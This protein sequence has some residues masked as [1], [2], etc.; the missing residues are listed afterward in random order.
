M[1]SDPSA[2]DIQHLIRYLYGQGEVAQY[3]R[4]T[5]IAMGSSAVD[6][7]IAV[8]RG[9]Y[10]IEEAKDPSEGRIWGFLRVMGLIPRTG[11]SKLQVRAE[12]AGILAEIGDHRA[13]EPLVTAF[14]NNALT[15]ERYKILDALCQMVRV[16]PDPRLI[17]V[18]IGVLDHRAWYA[19]KPHALLVVIGTLGAARDARAVPGLVGVLRMPGYQWGAISAHAA[20]ALG[21]IGDGRAVEPLSETL[22]SPE[23]AGSTQYECIRAL[24]QIGDARAGSALLTFIQAQLHLPTEAWADHPKNMGESD[25]GDEYHVLKAFFASAVRALRAVGDAQ[26]LRDLEQRLAAAPDWIPRH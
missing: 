24:E 23:A 13:V 11:R 15:S 2:N 1:E 16:S 7:L 17:D 22:L 19:S 21:K 6:P 12:A 9:E 26:M 25:W 14:Y 20:Q 3:A 5:L 4:R 18:L 8:L 10:E